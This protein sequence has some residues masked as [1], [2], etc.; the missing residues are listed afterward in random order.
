MRFRRLL[1]PAL[2]VIALGILAYVEFRPRV[3]TTPPRTDGPDFRIDGRDL[4]RPVQIVAYGDMRFTDP[5]ETSAANPKVRRWLVEKIAA[6]KP[7]VV[8]LSGDVTWKGGQAN[9]YAVYDSETKSWRDAHLRIYPALG[10]HELN[11]W[12]ERRCLENWWNAFPEL[13]G[14]RWYSVQLGNS[15]YLLNLDSN[16]SLMPESEQIAWVRSQLANLPAT[17]RFVFFNLHHPPVVDVQAGGDP[18]HNGRPNEK[19]LADFLAQT[20]EKSRVRFVVV[21]GHIHN[22]ERFFQNDIVYLVAGGGGGKPR[23]VQRSAADLY[24]D[25]AF[26]N[27]SYVRIVEN[28][29]TMEG[30]M[31]RIADPDASTPSWQEKDHFEITSVVQASAA[32]AGDHK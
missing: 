29:D 10:N 9:D 21:T 31:I 12:V 32:A 23:P 14:R 27:Y 28:G 13:R 25:S 17:V 3:V 22:Y 7:N 16:S 4:S 11:C 6:E 15:I 24:Q 1:L 5:N 19:A 30:T 20:P 2:G 18:S 8:L 26:P